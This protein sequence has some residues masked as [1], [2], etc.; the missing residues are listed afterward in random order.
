MALFLTE[1]LLCRHLGEGDVDELDVVWG[2]PA[3]MPFI[4]KGAPLSRAEAAEWVEG[5]LR[6]YASHGF[7]TSAVLERATGRLIGTCGVVQPHPSGP[8]ELLVIIAHGAWG[9][10]YGTEIS[11]GMLGYVFANFPAVVDVETKADIADFRGINLAQ[12]LATRFSRLYFARR[13]TY[14]V[15]SVERSELLGR[16]MPRAGGHFTKPRNWISWSMRT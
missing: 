15:Y 12:K 3:T 2:N 14:C 1:R 9:K 8:Y 11:R 16:A 10:G 7:G 5:C 4:G 13:R 6:R